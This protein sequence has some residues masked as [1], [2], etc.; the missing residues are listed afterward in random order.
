MGGFAEKYLA[1][2]TE[3]ELVQYERILNEIDPALNE[4]ICGV[5]PFPEDLA[6]TISERMKEFTASNPLN[7]QF[8]GSDQTKDLPAL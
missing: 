2:L 6:G 1:E 3:E 7:Y 4:W 5:K 8:A